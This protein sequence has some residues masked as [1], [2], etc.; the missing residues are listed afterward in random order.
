[1]AM[2]RFSNVRELKRQ[3]ACDE[4]PAVKSEFELSSAS[5]IVELFEGEGR[6]GSLRPRAGP[7]DEVIQADGYGVLNFVLSIV[8]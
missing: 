4:S 6:I 7:V 2:V 8:R 1:M 5:S 3:T